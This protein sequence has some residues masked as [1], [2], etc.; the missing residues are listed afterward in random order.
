VELATSRS[1]DA[2]S[3]GFRV[4]DALRAVARIGPPPEAW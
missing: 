2:V 3:L 4:G 1:G